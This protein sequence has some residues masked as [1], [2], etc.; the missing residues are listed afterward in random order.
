MP[1]SKQRPAYERGRDDLIRL[2]HRGLGRTEFVRRAAELLGDACHE[3]ACAWL[4]SILRT[5]S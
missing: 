4:P 5:S 1:S 2:T 3:P